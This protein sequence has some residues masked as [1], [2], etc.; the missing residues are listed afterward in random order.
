MTFQPH[1]LAV[2]VAALV[3]FFLGWIWY[4][5]LFGKQ[6]MAARGI[7]AQQIADGQRNMAR[8]MI[9][10]AVG[11]LIMAW[12]LGVLVSYLHLVTWMQGLKLG[13]LAW[14]GFAFAIGLID[15]VMTPGR[16][17]TAFYIDAAY[18]LITLVAMGII[19]SVWQ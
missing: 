12:A 15:S 7:T 5:P 4:T 3:G 8:N 17:V 10:V 1:Y 13:A 11:I 6:W 16:K 19:L 18:W 9:G 14:F 2:V